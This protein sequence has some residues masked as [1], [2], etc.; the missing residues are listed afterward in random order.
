MNLGF[1]FYN[2]HLQARL[3]AFFIFVFSSFKLVLSF[4]IATLKNCLN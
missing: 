4:E 3:Q 1:L 2:L